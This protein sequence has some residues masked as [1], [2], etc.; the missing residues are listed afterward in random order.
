MPKILCL[1]SHDLD[2]PE[3]GAMLRA[4]NVFRLL[5]Q[6]GEVRVV[7]AN[8]AEATTKRKSTGGFELAAVMPFQETTRRSL[9]NRL[10]YEFDGRFLNTDWQQA[11]AADHEKLEALLAAHDL[12]WIHGLKI[13]NGF[14]RWRWPNSILDIDDI[15]SGF[16]RSDMAHAKGVIQ[17]LRRYRQMR[18][19]Q[20]R[21]KNILE[22]FDALCVCSQTDRKELGAAGKIFVVPNGFNPPVN[23]VVRQPAV[24]PRIGFVGAFQYRPNREGMDW[25]VRQVWPQILRATPQARLRLIGAGSENISWP[26]DQN[27]DP[28][29]FVKDVESEMATWALSIVP[30]FVGGGTRIKIAE[31][32]SR[33]CP[34]VST[35]LGAHGYG[36]VD[37]REMFLADSAGDFAKKCLGILSDPAVGQGLAE[38]GWQ[39]F[40]ASW[41]W[42]SFGGRVAKAVESVLPK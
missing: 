37:G 42:D 22:R 26:S 17:K 30:V 4:R 31:A 6:L 16:H 2:G 29:G 35:T 9:T 23:P 1:T 33:R 19:W 5:A 12:V 7:L 13:A 14:G 40:M 18:L 41:T 32:F 15:P 36:A 8:P 39:R 10:R 28:L 20:R 38:N 27:I 11:S 34:I 24:P 25:F 3:Y 21:E